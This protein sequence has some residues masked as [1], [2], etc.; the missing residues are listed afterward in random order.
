MSSEQQNSRF[1]QHGPETRAIV[2]FAIPL[3]PMRAVSLFQLTP[4]LP[5][6]VRMFFGSQVAP[7]GCQQLVPS[8]L[9]RVEGQ[10][11][12]RLLT[13]SKRR[14]RRGLK[15]RLELRRVRRNYYLRHRKGNDLIVEVVTLRIQAL[16]LF[17]AEHAEITFF[18]QGSVYI[19]KI[20]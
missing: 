5:H 7:N 1:A 17:L 8:G 10:F 13:C 6:P 16:P 12:L 20:P 14:M 19:T 2:C 18:R 9:R 11:Q 3:A 15:R 4:H